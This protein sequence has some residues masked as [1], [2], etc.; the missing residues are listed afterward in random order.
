MGATFFYSIFYL[1]YLFNSVIIKLS[2]CEI[3][4]SLRICLP[5]NNVNREQIIPTLKVP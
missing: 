2:I 1:K 3:L 4:I 5:L